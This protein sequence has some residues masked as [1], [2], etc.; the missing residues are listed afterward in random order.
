VLAICRGN[1][2]DLVR[3]VTLEEAESFAHSWNWAY[4]ETSAGI[5]ELFGTIV[6][7]IVIGGHSNGVSEQP[8]ERA[9]R[10]DCC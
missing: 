10:D 8:L 7:S 5:G 3:E 4:V 9:D 1:K 6:S 2:S